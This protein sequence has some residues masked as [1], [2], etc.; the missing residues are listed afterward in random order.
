MRWPTPA[1]LLS[2]PGFLLYLVPCLILVHLSFK[3]SSL[4]S[5]GNANGPRLRSGAIDERVGWQGDSTWSVHEESLGM[6]AGAAISGLGQRLG[7]GGGGAR[8][9]ATRQGG[10]GPGVGDRKTRTRD[11]PSFASSFFKRTGGSLYEVG[12]HL[13]SSSQYIHPSR[14]VL[15]LPN[16]PSELVSC[17]GRPSCARIPN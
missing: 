16:P 2:R 7:V 6:K 14:D 9:S 8:G 15:T 4:S 1:T 17:R 5:N 10:P 13:S 3:S 11:D 12:G